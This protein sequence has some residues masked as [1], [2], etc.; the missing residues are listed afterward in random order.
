MLS[1]ATPATV[2]A[3]NSIGIGRTN[4]TNSSLANVGE[5]IIY[6]NEL[7]GSARNQVESYLAIKYGIT[8][9]QTTAT[10]YTLSNASTVWSALSAG[11]D[12]NN[13]AGIARDDVSTL[14]QLS[15]QS[16]TNTGDIIV[17]RSSIGTNRMALM[18]ANDG[19]QNTAFTGT[20]VPTGFQRLTREW[21]FQEK[22]G[23]LG[24]VNI[25]YPANALPGGLTGPLMLFTD[26]NSIFAT[27]STTYTGT[28]ST[29]SNTWDFSLNIA[30]LDYITFAKTVSVDTTPPV[31]SSVNIASGTLIPTGTFSYSFSYVDTG[32]SIN[33]G[34]V[35]LAI[36]SWNTGSSNWNATNL[37]GTYA[38]ITSATSAT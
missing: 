15:S 7:T 13:I 29:G 23:D 38:T 22:N 5:V 17:S 30:D 1:S 16:A 31:I 10:D 32:S 33:T 11:I 25:S 9:D 27:G 19:G 35:A 34:S 6:P 8:L 18:W 37:A 21:L 3:S 20:D 2:F 24:T 28:Y 14:S 36:Y 12:K 4:T 26:T